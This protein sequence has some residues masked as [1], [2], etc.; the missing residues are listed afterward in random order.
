MTQS[1]PYGAIVYTKAP[2]LLRQLEFV[3]GAQKFRE[4]VR[5]CLREHA[6]A[7][8]MWSDLINAFERASGQSLERWAT[9]WVGRRG[10]P[11]IEVD[12]RCNAQNRIDQLSIRQQDN[13]HEGSVW[14]VK[15]QLMLAYD[16]GRRNCSWL[17]LLRS[18][19]KFV[20]P[21]GENAL[22]TYSATI[23]TTATV[24]SCSIRAAVNK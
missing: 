13:L 21:Q 4:G 9:A 17:A 22:L 15:T 10:V 18:G 14:P 2:G 8:A 6:Y 20:K 23:M 24:C 7:N 11:Q 12:Y 3:L 19:R 1:P 16:N 5:L